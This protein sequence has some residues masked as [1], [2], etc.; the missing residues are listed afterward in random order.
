MYPLMYL[1]HHGKEVPSC[2]R[3]PYSWTSLGHFLGWQKHSHGPSSGYLWGTPSTKERKQKS[4]TGRKLFLLLSCMEGSCSGGRPMQRKPW[5]LPVC[6]TDG[7]PGDSSQEDPCTSFNQLLPASTWCYLSHFQWRCFLCWGWHTSWHSCG[8][9]GIFWWRWQRWGSHPSPAEK[10]AQRGKLIFL[11]VCKIAPN[12][13]LVGVWR[14]PCLPHISHSPASIPDDCFN[15][16]YSSTWKL[17]S[18]SPLVFSMLMLLLK[19]IL[20]DA[21]A[22]WPQHIESELVDKLIIHLTLSVLK[23]SQ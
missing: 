10:A 15:I 22:L 11:K 21:F 8:K 20:H 17:L 1:P 5:L 6:H 18:L 19:F 14:A 7:D 2:N 16:I 13:V 3:N 9:A 4:D 12:Y 23:D